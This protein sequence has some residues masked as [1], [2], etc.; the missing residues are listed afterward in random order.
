MI[1][2]AVLGGATLKGGEGTIS[3]GV[4]G[5][6]FIT[7]V[8]NVLII[9]RVDAFWQNI[10]VGVVLLLAVSLDRWKQSTAWPGKE[11]HGPGQ[12]AL[13]VHPHNLKG[14]R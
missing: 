7:L 1:T 11:S 3:G 14:F 8:N 4:M 9:T 6:I 5:V 12:P 10:V 13:L 2:A